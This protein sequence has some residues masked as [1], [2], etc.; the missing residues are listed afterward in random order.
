MFSS[1]IVKATAA[2]IAPL[3]FFANVILP[4]Q[5]PV[6]V[7]TELPSGVAVFE[8]SL[9]SPIQASSTSMTLA[10]VSIRGGGSLSGYQCFTIDEGSA[11]AEYVCGTASGTIIS[12]LERGLSPAD[13]VTEV[14]ALKF[15]HRRGA[16]VKIT[17][18]P[19]LQRLQAQNAGDATFESPLTYGASVSTSSLSTNGQNLASVAYAN[20][21]S[22]GAIAQAGTASG[23]FV[24]LATG[25]EAASSTASGTAARLVIPTTITTT[26]APT[27]GN[28]I[29]VTKADGNIDL[30]F[31]P[32]I[33]GSTTVRIF[34]A[35]ST[36][37]KP[38]TST[39]FKGIIVELVGGGG[40]GGSANS[41][42]GVGGGGGGGGGY[43]RE[44]LSADELTATSSVFITIG[45]AGLAL[46][47]TLDGL[48]G[49][50]TSFSTFASSTGGVG[51]KSSATRI[52]GQGGVGV[53]CD[54]NAAGSHGGSWSYVAADDG[55]GGIGGSSMFGG[56]GQP[57]LNNAGGNAIGFG[58]G[59]AGAADTA[60]ANVFG[61]NGTAG[62]AIIT[63]LY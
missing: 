31:L 1:L 37:S 26:T 48:T 3:L 17:N 34:T 47:S 58:G 41:S 44:H 30:G 8:T 11:Q 23:G 60:P 22:F 29:P 4:E 27:S 24:E 12:S 35:S 10:S 33:V 51:G 38:A 28:V 2:L 21:L 9:A 5:R 14:T 40:G 19:L 53:G 45:N 56:G 61:G 6:S 13:G 49:S 42:S 55:I 7:G 36:W 43:C 20:S 57:A 16:S 39:G 25:L 54:V 52:G 32:D 63:E 50:T 18:F 46:G 62:I 15:S 59:G